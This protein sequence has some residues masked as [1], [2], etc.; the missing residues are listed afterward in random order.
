[1]FITFVLHNKARH[2]YIE[3]II[4][5]CILELSAL[6]ATL[7]LDTLLLDNYSRIKMPIAQQEMNSDYFLCKLSSTYCVLH[8]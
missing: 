8:Y 7:L 1:M 5:L 3:N 6:F 4:P 2:P